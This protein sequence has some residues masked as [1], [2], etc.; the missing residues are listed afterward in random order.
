MGL[1]CTKLLRRYLVQSIWHNAVTMQPPAPN[2]K[3]LLQ[4]LKI[5]TNAGRYAKLIRDANARLIQNV[6]NR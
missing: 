5:Q 1:G 2:P 4:L 6:L 3:Q